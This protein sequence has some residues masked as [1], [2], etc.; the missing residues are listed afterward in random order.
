MATLAFNLYLVFIVSWF[1]HM[2]SRLEVLGVIRFDLLLLAAIVGLMVMTANDD[3]TEAAANHLNP[4]VRRHDSRT[5]TLILTLV[6][7]SL[8]TLPF[9]EWPGTV[10]NAG[11]PDYIKALVFFF[12]TARLVTTP[13]RLSRFLTV[14]I[15]SMTFRVLE[16]LYLHVTT[17]Y[18][19]SFATMAGGEYLDRLSGAPY[20]VINPNGLAFVVLT[21]IPFFH[22][23][24]PLTI[25]G[26]LLYFATLPL[27]LW[28]LLLTGSRSGMLG[29]GIV[30][31]SIWWKS[32]RKVLFG[33]L[34]GLTVVIVVPLLPPDLAD[35]YESITNSETKNAQTAEGRM[36]GLQAD[37]RIAMRR[38]LF[39][40]GLGTSLEAN[41]NFGGNDAPS[42]NLY[43]ETAQ[44]LGFIG[45]VILVA[46][47][48]S[49][50]S[51][52]RASLSALKDVAEVSPLMRRLTDAV[53]V[54]LAMNI[55][56]SFASYGLRSYE[57]YLAAG[58][59]DVLFR[60]AVQLQQSQAGPVPAAPLHQR[61]AA[62]GHHIAIGRSSRVDARGARPAWS[63]R[64]VR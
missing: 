12:F 17:G 48:F 52:L 22:Y 20:D 56:F 16:P 57:W 29:L 58:L 43:L 30:L 23:L 51:N 10:L 26:G 39:G 15:A 8:V 1:L 45:V 61:P 7:Y 55:L 49:I 53:Q 36:T 4:E 31:L 33:A 46:L 32:R 9:V 34:V 44:E 37:L 24:G 6:V 13:Q 11:L 27:L 21:V 38:P 18:W 62:L 41:A 50:G 14:F 60:Y 25:R 42:H 40:H 2:G 59:S 28:A 3:T 64:Q 35:R 63:G 54:W 5:R 19:G 47:L